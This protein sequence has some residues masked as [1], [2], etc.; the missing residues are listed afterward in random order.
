LKLGASKIFLFIST[1]LP[2]IIIYFMEEGEAGSWQRP[3]RPGPKGPWVR[4]EFI[5]GQGF[6]I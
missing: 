1:P 3:N 6:D 5:L 4:E 2:K